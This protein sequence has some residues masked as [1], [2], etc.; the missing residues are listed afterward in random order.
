MT[1]MNFNDLIRFHLLF[2]REDEYIEIDKVLLAWKDRIDDIEK[3]LS[4]Y[5]RVD[6]IY[7]KH[8]LDI[9]MFCIGLGINAM[10]YLS[11][12]IYNY[13]K[14]LYGVTI[15]HK[16]LTNLN[17]FDFFNPFNFIV[18]HP[19]KDIVLLYQSDYISFEEFKSIIANYRIDT[20]SATF[21]MARLLYRVDVF[22]FLE[23]KRDLEADQK[24]NFNLKKEIYKIKKAYSLLKEIYSIR[25]IDWLEESL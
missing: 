9:S 13:D 19:L 16:R 18:E 3:K 11:D 2:Y 12:A 23:T 14:K 1:N 25:P 20:L 17:S 7:Y 5:L 15:V 22:D 4:S 24:I 10:Q 21:C 8:N 6:S